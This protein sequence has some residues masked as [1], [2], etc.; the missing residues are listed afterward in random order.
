MKWIIEILYKKWSMKIVYSVMML[1]MFVIK[2]YCN[3]WQV[4]NYLLG[5]NSMFPETLKFSYFQV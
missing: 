3:Y 1:I 2:I 4:E 5:K